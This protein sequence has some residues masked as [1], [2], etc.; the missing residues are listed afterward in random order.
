MRNIFSFH[1]W[2]PQRRESGFTIV[3]LLIVVVVIAI[4]AAITVTAY[5][6][7]QERAK[8]S[9]INDA[10]SSWAKILQMQIA[11]GAA[12][13]LNASCLGRSATDFPAKDGFAAGE[14]LQAFED[15][16]KTASVEYKATALADWK[17]GDT[18]PNGLL[19]VT[20]T[21]F[22]ASGKSYVYKS[23]G[24]W[25]ATIAPTGGIAWIPVVAGQCGPGRSIAN[26]AGAQLGSNPLGGDLCGYSV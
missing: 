11:Q 23:R 12:I 4:L 8:T 3:E 16:V 14:C 10:A 1:R 7:V 21:S 17:G 20:S 22:T 24:I 25:L 2:V 5:S 18:I 6:G 26:E 15:G 13:S 19:P 9:V